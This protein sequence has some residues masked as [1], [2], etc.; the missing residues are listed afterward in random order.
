MNVSIRTYFAEQAVKNREFNQKIWHELWNPKLPLEPELPKI[1][2]R[3]LVLWG[4]TDRVLDPSGVEVL[5][6]AMP[7]AE[8]VILK[9]CGHVPMIEQPRETADA[10]LRF[11]KAAKSS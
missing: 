5:K 1:T 2:A 3:T 4:D 9:D 6:A 7:A 8:V 11:V 10:Y